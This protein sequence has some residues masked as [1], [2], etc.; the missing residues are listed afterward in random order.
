MPVTMSGLTTGRLVMPITSFFENPRIASMLTAAAEPI[1]V[2]ISDDSTAIAMVLYSALIML[3]S[4]KS[5]IYQLKVKPLHTALD[6]DALN[7]KTIKIIIGAY[8]N[9][10]INPK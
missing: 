10:S 1:T 4:L 2:A 7:E 5:S 9:S 6:F 8:I 3:G